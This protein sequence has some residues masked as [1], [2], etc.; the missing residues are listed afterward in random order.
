MRFLPVQ[1]QSVKLSTTL[2]LL[3]FGPF[4]WSQADTLA[5]PD[6]R[7]LIEDFY[8]NVE[9][10]ADFDFNTL[11][12]TLEDYRQRPL[13]LNRAEE[14]ELLEL[15]L[16]TQVQ[17]AALLNHRIRYGRLVT[18]YEL[19]TIPGFDRETI[20]RILPFVRVGGDLDRSAASLTTLLSEGESTLFLRY[21]R[22]L[23]EQR[24]YAPPDP[25]RPDASRYLGN[26]D[27][28]YLRYRFASGRSLSAGLTA[29]KDP[30]EPFWNDSLRRRGFDFYSAHLFARNRGP[31]EAIAL[32]DF[33]VSL[34]QG[35]I[36]NTGFVGG[37]SANTLTTARRDPVLRPYTSVNEASFLRGAGASIRWD[38]RWEATGFVSYRRRDGNLVEQTTLVDSL[39]ETA[40]DFTLSS[41]LSTGFHRT[42]NE[43]AD[44]NTLRQFTTGGRIGYRD[45][46]G[47][48]NLN[49]VYN[50]FDRALTPRFQPYRQFTFS[51]RSLLNVSM[52]YTY[53]IRNLSLFGESARSDN[54]GW[55][56]LH[57]LTLPVDRRAAISIVHRH[58]QVDYQTLN[59][60]PFGEGSNGSNETGLYFGLRFVPAP[61]WVLAA[62]FD[63]FRF[64]FLRFRVDAPSRGHEWLAR[65]TYTRRRNM[66]LYGEVRREI[67]PFNRPDSETPFATIVPRD[68][69]QIRLHYEQRVDG[70]WTLRSRLQYGWV[71]F[72]EQVPQ[73]GYMLYQDLIF[74]S[75]MRALSGN[76]RLAIFDTESFETRFYAYENDVL[77]A[78]SIPAYFGRG[79]RTYLNL[80]YR[81][82]RNLTLEGRW[83]QT[84]FSD[85]T[86]I[87]SGL[88]TIDGNRRREVKFQLRYRF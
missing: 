51:G 32:G 76:V 16:L 61:N 12:E 49:T 55:G 79:V 19:Q 88:E 81:V 13:N 42:A 73:K 39:E 52:D 63:T 21:T 3:L 26:P 44:R 70:G 72:G 10:D 87:G 47:G 80:R 22:V 34:G 8:Q 65:L 37:K 11:L 59:A 17:V 36:L 66:I 85:R 38:D 9:T 57:G 62:Y 28:Y 48:V 50:A 15:Q 56:F 33:A 86:E 18:V 29:E 68:R 83:A 43:L 7:D 2:F 41:I 82:N 40:L 58:Y 75:R 20:L 5:P 4:A 60:R 54:G 24:G 35:L 14:E 67:K 77:Y 23:D 69:L 46:R 71:Q 45:A 27:R 25:D 84:R 31:F 64:P 74:R 6:V 53:R 30:G 78:F 1:V